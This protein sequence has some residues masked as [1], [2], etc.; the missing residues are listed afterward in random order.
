MD[1]EALRVAHVGQERVQ[2]DVVDEVKA[3]LAP[4]LN[5]KHE[6]TTK[7]MAQYAARNLVAGVVLEAGVAHP[8]DLGMLLEEARDSQGVVA[9]AL[10]AQAQRLD[11]NANELRR[12]GAERWPKIAQA[13]GEHARAKGRRRSSLG[14]HGAVVRLVRLGERG[15]L[16]R[17]GCPV[18]RAGIHDGAAQGVA[19]AANPLGKT[20][21]DHCRTV[22]RRPIEIG[23]RK[24]VVHDDRDVQRRCRIYERRDVGHVHERVTDGLHEPEL[25]V[26]LGSRHKGVDVVV[27]HKGSLDTQVVEGVEQDVPR[28]AVERVGGHDVVARTRDVGKGQD[29]GCV[30]RGNG[31]RRG[32]AL[33]RGDARGNGIGG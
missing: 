1:D 6:H 15:K 23:R 11:A 4:A 22:L 18:K 30:S 20:L 27:G 26:F 9:V 31:D 8:R 3:R 7:A 12:I 19:V 17:H 10:H 25:G 28:T 24:G 16:A 29:L 13:L 32:R 21:D 5:A 14:P 2:L 33:Y